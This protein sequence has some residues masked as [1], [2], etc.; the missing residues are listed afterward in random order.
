MTTVEKIE[1]LQSDWVDT[2]PEKP[3]TYPWILKVVRFGFATLGRIFPRAAGK[4]AFEL[5]ATPRTRAKHRTPEP[6][7]AEARIFDVLF[8]KHLLKCYAWGSGERTV[9]L[10]HGWES[11]GTALRSFVPAL[12]EQGYR[13]V[14]MD[15][16]AHGDSGGTKTH[17]RNFGQAVQTVIRRLGD[18]ESIITHSFGG[19]ATVYAL[20]VLDT[21]IAIDKLVLIGTPNRM[22]NV[23][24]ASVKTMNVPRVAANHYRRLTEEKARI[25]LSEATL[26]KLGLKAQV[27]EALIVHDTT[28]QAVSLEAAQLLAEAWPHARM[29]V[30]EGYGH[31]RLMKNPDVIRRVAEFVGESR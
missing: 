18:V 28:D 30:T 5:F 21:S 9:L 29:L 11:R 4:K 26:S 1:Y 23:W 2:R 27:K 19:A 14:A 12:V 3:I 6:L 25:P 24:K 7:L 10:V 31:F 17:I 8:G 22:E 20:S 13:V 16:P 15:G